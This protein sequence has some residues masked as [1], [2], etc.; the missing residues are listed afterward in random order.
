ARRRWPRP[1][2]TGGRWGRSQ[3]SA[4]LSAA[5]PPP[6]S[7]P[8]RRRGAAGIEASNAMGLPGT[9]SQDSER[10]PQAQV[11]SWPT[12]TGRRRTPRPL[13]R[14]SSWGTRPTKAR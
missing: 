6:P 1:A 12:T 7:W 11:A 8:R 13:R 5:S 10:R 3:P 9:F 2:R 4:W 14:G